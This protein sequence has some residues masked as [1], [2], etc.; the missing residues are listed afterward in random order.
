MK[1]LHCL[2]INLGMVK[3]YYSSPKYSHPD[4]RITNSLLRIKLF[5]KFIK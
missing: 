1:K 4:S 5:N 3:I 2:K